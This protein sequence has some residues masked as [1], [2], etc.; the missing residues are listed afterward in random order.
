MA[1]KNQ[2]II[3]SFVPHAVEVNFRHVGGD[4][5][6]QPVKVGIHPKT[7]RVPSKHDS[8]KNI[9]ILSAEDFAA[10]KQD[11]A[12]YLAMGQRRGMTI[13]EDIPSGYWDPAQRVASAEAEKSAALAAKAGAEKKVEELEARVEEL[14]GFLKTYGWKDDGK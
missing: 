7:V 2:V 11:L 3:Q 5:D 8:P 10:V 6:G 9:L 12:P 1:K 13:I 4:L 14:K